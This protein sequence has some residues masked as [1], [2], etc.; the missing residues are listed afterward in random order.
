[1]D[2]NLHLLVTVV[3]NAVAPWIILNFLDIAMFL[4]EAEGIPVIRRLQSDDQFSAEAK[5]QTH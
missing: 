3:T 1:M 5:V 2:V 4:T